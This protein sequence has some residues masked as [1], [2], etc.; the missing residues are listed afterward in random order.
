MME[1]MPFV[2]ERVTGT[3][4]IVTSEIA[5]SLERSGTVTHFF[6]ARTVTANDAE[7]TA[8]SPSSLPA[9]FAELTE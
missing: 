2:T 7:N 4:S 3:P 9:Y 1:Y 5:A 6:S 8:L